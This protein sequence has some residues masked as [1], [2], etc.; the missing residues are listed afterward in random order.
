MEARPL[1]SVEGLDRVKGIGPKRL[2]ELR[3]LFRVE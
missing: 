1:R 3:L 2:A